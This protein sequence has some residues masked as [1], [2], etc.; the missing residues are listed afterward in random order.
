MIPPGKYRSAWWLALLVSFLSVASA[1]VHGIGVQVTTGAIGFL[2]Y[3]EFV[4]NVPLD[5]A[6]TID[7]RQRLLGIVQLSVD[8]LGVL[9]FLMWVYRANKNARALGAAGMKYTPGW[10]V[11]W[12]F[13]PF[14]GLFMPYWVLKEIWQVSSPGSD[15]RLRKTIVSP[16]L[17][18]WWLVGVLSGTIRYSRWHYFKSEGPTTFAL[19]FLSKWPEELTGNR[20]GLINSELEWCWGLMLGDVVGI[21]AC[22]LTIV[23]ILTITGMQDRKQAMILE[24][25]SVQEEELTPVGA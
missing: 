22:T 2:D 24:L 1:V 25:Q 20:P 7:S 4:V 14:A 16:V 18:L 23:V 10:S 19:E 17:A 6:E 5:R 12:F 9:L 11:G 21:A 8:F 3:A 15:D 13:V